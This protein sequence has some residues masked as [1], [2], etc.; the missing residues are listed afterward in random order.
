[1]T[2]D[3]YEL[4]TCDSHDIESTKIKTCTATPSDENHTKRAYDS[5]NQNMYHR[6]A[7]AR[8]NMHFTCRRKELVDSPDLYTV[9]VKKLVP[10]DVPGQEQVGSGCSNEPTT[11][12]SLTYNSAIFSSP[13]SE[14]EAISSPYSE[15]VFVSGLS[16]PEV[17][18]S[19]DDN[20]PFIVTG[21]DGDSKVVNNKSVIVSRE[22]V[23]VNCVTGDS[24]VTTSSN[25]RSLISC[26]IPGSELVN[27]NSPRNEHAF[28]CGY[29]KPA[30][31]EQLLTAKENV[32][33]PGKPAATGQLLPARENVRD[34]GKPVATEQMLTARENV[35][36]PGKPMTTEQML[37]ARENVRD[38]GKPVATEQMLT[39]KEN[40]RDPG[41]PVATEQMLTAK[42]NVPDPGKPAATGQLLTAR[43]NVR[44]PG[45]P[46]ATERMLTTKE[47]VW[48]PGKPATTGQLL[49]EKGNVLG[50]VVV[51]GCGEKLEVTCDLGNESVI[52]D[53]LNREPT[54]TDSCVTEPVVVDM[55]DKGPMNIDSPITEPLVVNKCGKKNVIVVKP[56]RDLAII[57]ALDEGCVVGDQD[58]K[59]VV[60]ADEGSSVSDSTDTVNLNEGNASQNTSEKNARNCVGTSGSYDKYPKTSTSAR[61]GDVGGP[62]TC[63]QVIASYQAVMYDHHD[64]AATR[65]ELRWVPF[66]C[67][68]PYS[69]TQQHK[70]SL[71]SGTMYT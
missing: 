68:Y 26:S 36:D 61:D 33:D 69:C 20:K 65:L 6:D 19:C 23:S 46:V 3:I 47:N 60:L 5:G 21:S 1:V 67:Q 71:V 50:P 56:E 32:W 12:N 62:A 51:G 34:P 48:D 41:K 42:E 4:D 63:D 7:S 9:Y 57:S 11:I 24:V 31:T 66:C 55:Y 59:L 64:R 45:K 16:E 70:S 18:S 38:P 25:E 58:R 37:T 8:G 40:V 44:D 13:T 29:R 49:T 30:A 2:T 17:L 43:E 22:S 52:A 53:T 28:V 14:A 35:R 10:F 27:D 15:P 54:A 39:A